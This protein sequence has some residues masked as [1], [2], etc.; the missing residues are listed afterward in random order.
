[1]F[2]KKNQIS[3]FLDSVKEKNIIFALKD[4]AREIA[5]SFPLLSNLFTKNSLQ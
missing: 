3:I 1:V 4:E 5:A 2:I